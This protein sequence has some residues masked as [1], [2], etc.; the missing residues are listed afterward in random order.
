MAISEQNSRMNMRLLAK[1]I[2]LISFL[3]GNTVFVQTNY[4]KDFIEF[5][6]VI[7]N[8]YAYLEQ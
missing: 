4:Q 7:D 5:W 3:A 6:T 8:H 1:L 2:L